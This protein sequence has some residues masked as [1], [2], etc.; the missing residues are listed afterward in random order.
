MRV[1][2]FK[3]DRQ[4]VVSKSG[5]YYVIAR[6]K[7]TCSHLQQNLLTVVCQVWKSLK[8]GSGTLNPGYDWASFLPLL[9]CISC[10]IW[11]RVHWFYSWGR[12][13]ERLT[14]TVSTEVYHMPFGSTLHWTRVESSRLLLDNTNKAICYRTALTVWKSELNRVSPTRVSQPDRPIEIFSGVVQIHTTNQSIGRKQL[15]CNAVN[16]SETVGLLEQ[17]A[18]CMERAS[19]G[20]A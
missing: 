9:W 6:L 4:I 13:S 16:Q 18:L 17:V 11:S 1:K 15:L 8:L 20:V 7:L 14:S 10:D 12:G 5:F 19:R 2:S 3:M